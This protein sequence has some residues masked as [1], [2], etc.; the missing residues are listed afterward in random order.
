MTEEDIVYQ[1]L[2]SPPGRFSQGFASK[3]GRN[4]PTQTPLQP[5]SVLPSR[6]GSYAQPK[7]QYRQQD[8]TQTGNGIQHELS[9]NTRRKSK[10]VLNIGTLRPNKDIAE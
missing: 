9:S 8:T 5:E 6:Q 2:L 7:R 3:G 1:N 4:E 10:G